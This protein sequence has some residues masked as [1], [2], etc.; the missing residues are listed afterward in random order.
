MIDEQLSTLADRVAQLNGGKEI[1]RELFA[2]ASHISADL[3]AARQRYLYRGQDV[4]LK[5]LALNNETVKANWEHMEARM[6]DERARIA[7]MLAASD[8]WTGS[9]ADAVA[10]I[11][12]AE[13]PP[14]GA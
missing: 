2:L 8:L 13:A 12:P 10:L 3:E 6:R 4:F 1:A 5:L 14:A 11:G 7:R 9:Y